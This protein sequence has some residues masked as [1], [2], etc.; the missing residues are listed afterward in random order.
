MTPKEVFAT[1]VPSVIQRLMIELAL[2]PKDCFAVLGNVGHE[3]NGFTQLQEVKPTVKGSEG[4]YGWAQWTG[5]RRRAFE[6]WCLKQRL[7]VA[8]DAANLGFLVYELK[9]S[10]AKA[11]EAVKKAMT[12]YDKVVAFELAYERAGV[13]HY[14]SR[15]QWAQEAERVWGGQSAPK[16]EEKTMLETIIPTVLTPILRHGL[17]ALAGVLVT[18]GLLA[19]DQTG[20]FATI[21][22]GIIAGILG[23]G[24]SFTKNLKQAPK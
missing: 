15:M 11:V 2:T 21:V 10:E 13:K 18:V 8:S 23:M 14:D 24:W 16:T 12:L 6:A 4:G 9:T 20:N 7:S 19:P 5:V 22:S 17:T 1:K 3:C